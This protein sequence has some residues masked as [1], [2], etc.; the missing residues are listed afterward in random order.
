MINR[1]TGTL[2]LEKDSNELIL[3]IK[4]NPII[5]LFDLPI[6]HQG[7]G[8]LGTGVGTS[9]SAV[10]GADLLRSRNFLFR[11]P[12]DHTKTHRPKEKRVELK[13]THYSKKMRTF[14]H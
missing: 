13:T 2:R 1:T 10:A 11:R 5:L 7:K 6:G 4:V 9:C 8:A 14:T 3:F 12:C